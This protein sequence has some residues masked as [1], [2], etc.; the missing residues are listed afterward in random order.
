MN[1]EFKVIGFKECIGKEDNTYY[2]PLDIDAFINGDVIY[3]KKHRLSNTF[4]AYDN[5]LSNSDLL[6]VDDNCLCLDDF[7]ASDN[8]FTH[9][10]N[11]FNGLMQ[12]GFITITSDGAVFKNIY[13]TSL[14]KLN[15]LTHHRVRSNFIIKN[16]VKDNI[17][18]V[19]L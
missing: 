15:I 5:I 17:Y 8:N 2:C 11:R 7:N 13:L 16:K 18:N 4:N 12:A 6:L 14:N 10:D 9:D 19:M 3:D 1:L